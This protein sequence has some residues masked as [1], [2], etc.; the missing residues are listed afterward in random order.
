[1]QIEFSRSYYRNAKLLL[2]SAF[3]HLMD[4]GVEL[5]INIR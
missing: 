5:Y 1:M 4:S 3:N 2:K